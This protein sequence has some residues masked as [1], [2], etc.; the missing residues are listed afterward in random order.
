MDH[1]GEVRTSPI[2]LPQEQVIAAIA[3]LA[4]MPTTQ[5]PPA[6]FEPGG[7]IVDK[8]GEST[9]TEL[10][11]AFLI[12]ITPGLS[13]A[14]DESVRGIIEK[15]VDSYQELMAMHQEASSKGRKDQDAII[16]T[17]GNSMLG[18]YLVRLKEKM[19]EKSPFFGNRVRKVGLLAGA[20]IKKCVE[21]QTPDEESLQPPA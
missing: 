9:P 12:G 2:A 10:A 19:L 13:E 4:E 11:V 18:V 1:D 20:A 21:L 8:F 15:S 17:L 7:V 16:G 3:G 6:R 5:L 14:D